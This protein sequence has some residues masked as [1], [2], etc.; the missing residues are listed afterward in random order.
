MTLSLNL[1]GGKYFYLSMKTSLEKDILLQI[2]YIKKSHHAFNREQ[3]VKH[4]I[5]AGQHESKIIIPTKKLA[6][7]RLDF[8]SNPKQ[9]KISNLKISGK[10]TI[11]FN[12]FSQFELL[13]ID[14]FDIKNNILSFK[15]TQ[16]NPQIVYK[17]ILNL[18]GR[19]HFDI[20]M[21]VILATLSFLLSYKVVKYLSTFKIE[22]HHSRIDIVFLSVFF[23]LLFLPMSDI[24]KAEKSEQENRIL[25]SRPSFSQ[26]F[27][28]S[29]NYGKA[30]EQWFNDHFFGRKNLI[31]LN[32]K[33]QRLNQYYS[34]AGAQKISDDWS[35][36]QSDVTS[37]HFS[38]PELFAIKR[39]IE[40]YNNFC[41]KNG[42]KC[43]I[44]IVPKKGEFLKDSSL[45]KAIDTD[46]S[47]VIYKY[48]N[49]NNITNVVYPLDALSKHNQTDLVYFKTDH[50]WTEWGAY[51]G[52]QDLMQ[53][54]K[55]DFPRLVPVTEQ[56]YDIF[57]DNRV[58]AE[59]DRSFWYGSACKLLKLD[60]KTCPLN[61]PYRYYKHKDEKSLK[62]EWDL[63][64]NNKDF[65]YP[66]A[67]N[68]EKVVIIG[69][70]FTENFSSFLAY[71]FPRIKKFRSNNQ[72]E[73]SLKI[74]RWEKDILA[75][76]PD[77]MLIVINSNAAFQLNDLMKE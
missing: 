45:K 16:S 7:F 68:K 32:T 12:D 60:E 30:F 53:R 76:K 35:V 3:S 15:S 66:H 49:K 39:S 21:F 24:S 23:V 41:H 36:I 34:Y 40:N 71:T 44:E 63:K 51:W 67:K 1:W 69:N 59:G 52:Y 55:Q 58:R 29:G 10:K 22:Q 50:H 9:V 75:F 27:D 56:D 61:T 73:D 65:Y 72:F 33:L 57:Y 74:S 37:Q 46:H 42:I 31:E 20:Y 43:Y 19:R 70:S 2:D 18:K 77:I 64:Y 17:N 47:S 14:S 26:F 62:M 4:L 25:A 48:L 5:K 11:S 13:N 38:L 6:C 8:G 54:I 28:K